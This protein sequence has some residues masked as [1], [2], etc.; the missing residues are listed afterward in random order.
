MKKGYKPILALFA[1]LAMLAA[2]CGSDSGDSATTTEAG[3]SGG[4][5]F[6]VA[7]VAP[8]AANDL[9]FTQSMHDALE[10]LKADGTISDYVI[11]ENMFV[12]EDAAAALRDYADGGYDLVI[13]HGSQYG[14]SLQEIAPDFPET[15]FVWGTAADTFGV[16]N[17]SAYS[18]SA[19]QGGYVLGVMAAML[20][21]SG[22]IGVVGPR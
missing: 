22:Q 4:D 5:E 18:A 11:S 7:V 15:A 1:A 2:A 6:T 17:I 14:A 9:A 20:S 10:L 21:E 13:G 3:A 8:S 16:A 12:V 19:D